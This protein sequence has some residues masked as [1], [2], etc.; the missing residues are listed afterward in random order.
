VAIRPVEH[1]PASGDISMASSKVNAAGEQ[2]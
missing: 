2:I 1:Q